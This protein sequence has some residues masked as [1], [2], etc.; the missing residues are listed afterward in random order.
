MRFKLFEGTHSGINW[1]YP[2]SLAWL[3]DRLSITL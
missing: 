1:R 3:V 2:L